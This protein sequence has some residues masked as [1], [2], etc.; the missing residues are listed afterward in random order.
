[1]ITCYLALLDSLQMMGEEGALEELLRGVDR[2]V[3]LRRWPAGHR[4]VVTSAAAT[5]RSSTLGSPPN[6][7]LLKVMLSQREPLFQSSDWKE[8]RYFQAY[9]EER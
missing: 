9:P 5:I 2:R 8:E 3:R 6:P 4:P 1:M 7:F